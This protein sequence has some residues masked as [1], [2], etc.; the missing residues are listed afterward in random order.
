MPG[1]KNIIIAAAVC[2][3]AGSAY[4][5][6]GILIVQK[7]TTDGNVRTNQ[8][9][10]DATHMRAEMTGMA[11]RSQTF[12]FDGDKQVMYTIDV[13]KKTYS[14]ITK[15]DVDKIAAQMSGAMAQMQEALKSMPPERRAQ[16]E[17]IMKGRLGGAGT[18]DTKPTFKKV[19]TDTVGK[20]KC[21]KYD[22]YEGTQKT[23]EICTVDP[24]ALGFSLSDFAVTKQMMDFFQRMLPP[25]V[26]SSMNA[27]QMWALGNIQDQGYSGF[28]IRSIHGSTT[29]ELSDVTRQNFP[30]STFAPPAG[31]Q[32]V[33]SPL[34]SMGGRGR[35]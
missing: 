21:D 2:L 31:Y 6:D 27:S 32:K 5:A 19:G 29:S 9:Q 22:E 13:D 16:M 34:A 28:P 24:K 1:M 11:G 26:R 3:C 20:W 35:R 18:A 7:T 12:I 4:A 14:E 10:L 23:S 17:S 30:A 25:S 8:V 15:E 33:A